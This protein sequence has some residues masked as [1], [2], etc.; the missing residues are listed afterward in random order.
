MKAMWVL[1]V[2]VQGLST[3]CGAEGP[4][5]VCNPRCSSTDV[6]I[7]K[8]CVDIGARWIAIIGGTFTMGCSPGDGSCY[9]NELPTHSV[10]LSPFEILET[11][12]TVAQFRAVV[13]PD[14]WS[15]DEECGV[16]CPQGNVKWSEAEFFCESIGGRLPSEAEWEYAARG[17]TTSRFICG[18]EPECLDTIAWW[19]DWREIPPEEGTKHPVGSKEPNGFGLYDMLGSN[20]EWTADCE[21]T[22]TDDAETDPRLSYPDPACE[23]ECCGFHLRVVR[24]GGYADTDFVLPID[25]RV[26]ARY[27]LPTVVDKEEVGFRCVR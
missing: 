12:V 19:R 21:R 16:D 23:D 26:S 6:C 24:G 4:S 5:E 13:E 10:T 1:V 7:S 8:Q 15:P 9:N 3:G 14:S 17:G 2:L 11:E 27:G 18:D 20:W 22:Y 25:Y